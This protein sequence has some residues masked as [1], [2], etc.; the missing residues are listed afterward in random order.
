MCSG[1]KAHFADEMVQIRR[2]NSR[3]HHTR[4]IGAQRSPVILTES[5][6]SRMFV[7]CSQIIWAENGDVLGQSDLRYRAVTDSDIKRYTY[8]TGIQKWNDLRDALA[9][10]DA[11]WNG[12]TLN[13]KSVGHR[14]RAYQGRRLGD[15]RLVRAR[16]LSA[17]QK[18]ALWKIEQ[19][20]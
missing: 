10:L 17:H 1:R 4:G 11:Y 13:L 5:G 12:K 2:E 3:I 19:F 6:S 9:T 20:P 8:G 15:K 18:V 16:T 7:G 14:L